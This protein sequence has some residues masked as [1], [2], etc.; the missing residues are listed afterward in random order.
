MHTFDF[1][2]FDQLVTFRHGIAVERAKCSASPDIFH[3]VGIPLTESLESVQQ[4]VSYLI[5]I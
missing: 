4:N 5:Q 3:Q 1:Q 2:L